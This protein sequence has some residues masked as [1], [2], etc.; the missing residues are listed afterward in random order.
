MSFFPQKH[1]VLDFPSQ[2]VGH[3]V[4]W[5][6]FSSPVQLKA[7]QILG[8]IKNWVRNFLEYDAEEVS[9]KDYFLGLVVGGES[10]RTVNYI[11]L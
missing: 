7:T 8:R 5:F 4:S 1:Q 6:I 11:F 10:G 2:K 3:T 9:D